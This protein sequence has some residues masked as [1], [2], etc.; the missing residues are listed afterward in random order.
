[1]IALAAFG[2][3]GL[4]GAQNLYGNNAGG[5]DYIYVLNPGTGVVSQTLSSLN[6]ACTNGRGIVVVSGVIYYT[7]A[8]GNSVYSYTL[9]SH[10]DNGVLFHV[11]A[12]SALS[13]MAFDGTNFW[14]GDYGGINPGPAYLYSRTGTLLKTVTLAD[15]VANC[16]GLEYFLQGGSIPRLIS[17]R[18]DAIDPYDVYDTNGNLITASFINPTFAGTGIAYDG[19]NFEVSEIFNAKF[20]KYSGTTGTLM[21]ETAITGFTSGFNPLVEDLSADYAVVLGG[22]QPSTAPLPSTL[23]LALSAIVL[24]MGAALLRRRLSRT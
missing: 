1:M 11:A 20:A 22:P 23:I 16:D 5:T 2:C 19:T 12:A 6:G 21:S 7:C 18:G 4:A 13:T 3:A 15:C 17:N 10:T 9:A 24:L 14:I 8:N